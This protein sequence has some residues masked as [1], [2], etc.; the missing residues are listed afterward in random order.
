[1]RRLGQPG[2]ICFFP[3]PEWCIIIPQGVALS[4][5]FPYML[6]GEDNFWMN[7]FIKYFPPK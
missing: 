7:K 6:V 3:R 4:C 1:M 2:P 5:S